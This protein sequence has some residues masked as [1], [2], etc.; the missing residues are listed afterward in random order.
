VAQ[1]IPGTEIQHLPWPKDRY[2]VETGDFVADI[3]KIKKATGWAPGIGLA[4]G[5]QKTVDFYQRHRE[6]YW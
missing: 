2:F 4:E 6:H 5:I 3:S 1:T